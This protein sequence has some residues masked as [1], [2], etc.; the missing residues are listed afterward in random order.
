MRDQQGTW[1]TRLRR[2][3]SR[4]PRRFVA[5]SIG[6]H[7]VLVAVAYLSGLYQTR[8]PEFETYRVHLI[9]PPPTEAGEPE[10]VVTTTPVVTPPPPEPEPAPPQ[11]EPRVEPPPTPPRT[12]APTPQPPER[13]PDPPP[14]RGPDPVPSSVGGENLRIEQDGREFQYPEYLENIMRQLTRYMRPPPGQENLEAEVVFYINRDGSVG[15]IR[16][17]QTSGS[18][19]FNAQA[20]QAVEQAGRARAFGPLP[21]DWQRDRL[22]I[23]YTFERPR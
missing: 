11:P 7:A 2:R 22:Y 1:G 19:A 8:V 5:Y 21:A 18:F 13:R 6:L 9:S 17:S 12:Q 3:Q 16:I 14:A 15:G 4:P 20:M 23:A 10:P